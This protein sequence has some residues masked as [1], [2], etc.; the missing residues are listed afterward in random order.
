M[1]LKICCILLFAAILPVF[2]LDPPKPTMITV[3]G[4]SFFMGS[5][6]GAYRNN[7][8]VHEVTVKTFLISETLV[9]QELYMAVMNE[10]PSVFKG[11]ANPVDSVSWFEAVA[12]CNALSIKVGL[13]PAY[14]IEE[15]TVSWNRD[16]RGYRLPTEAEWEFAARGGLFGDRGPLEKAFFSGGIDETSMAADYCWFSQNSGRTT[17]PVKTKLP[18]QLGIYDMS[19]NVWEWCWDWHVEYPTDSVSGYAGP[20]TGRRRIYRGGSYYNNTNMQRVTF[21]I[22]DDPAL[23]ANSRGFRIVQNGG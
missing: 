20:D 23:K 9:T 22:S 3:K 19:G 17:H 6:E 21:R 5:N 8:K 10:N 7:E 16:A 18:N 4:G 12:F 1:K 13:T 11:A 15:T 14:I 2:A